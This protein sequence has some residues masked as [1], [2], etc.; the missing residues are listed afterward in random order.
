MSRVLARQAVD[1][2]VV[3][4]ALG[5]DA[6]TADAVALDEGCSR[7]LPRRIPHTRP[8][9]L[10]HLA[11]LGMC[12]VVLGLSALLSVRGRTQVVL[13]L[14]PIPLP[15][16]CMSRRLLGW[17]CPGCGLTRCFISLARGDVA[18]A[19]SYN[20]AG[21]V[22]F[23]IAVFQIPYRG[24]QLWRIR[25]GLPEASLPRTAQFALVLFLMALI[26]QWALRV[27]GVSF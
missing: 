17:D 9:P 3:A 5:V 19:W 23:A 21:L 27:G 8:D 24:Y 1:S 18:S 15:E 2:P 25:R 4:D 6:L 7:D 10:F 22:L 13:P 26:L 16:L 12:V 20:P 11:L 14:A